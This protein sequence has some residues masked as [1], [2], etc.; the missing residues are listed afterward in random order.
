MNKSKK[1]ISHEELDKKKDGDNASAR[2]R[3]IGSIEQIQV[4]GPDGKIQNIPFK[5]KDKIAYE[6]NFCPVC[7]GENTFHR[8]VQ[9]NRDIVNNIWNNPSFF[10]PA[11]TALT[12]MKFD[13][14]LDCRK[15]FVME[16]FIL[17]KVA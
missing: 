2:Y 11:G 8:R 6:P 12:S 7:E 13:F 10:N 3:P 14:C 1:E 15:E 16:I 9:Q 5:I 4:Q 17:E